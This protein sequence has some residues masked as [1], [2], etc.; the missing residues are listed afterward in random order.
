MKNL[1]IFSSKSFLLIILVCVTAIIFPS[2]A[3]A[4]S[5]GNS[6]PIFSDQPFS[7]PVRTSDFFD[8]FQAEGEENQEENIILTISVVIGLL[9]IASLVGIITS[10]LRLPYTVGLVLI[11]LALSLRGQE[12]I[13]IPPEIFLGLLVPPLIFEAAFHIRIKDLVKD[14]VPILALAIPGVLITTLL[15]GGVVA[16]GTGFPIATALV[17]GALVAATDPVAV[18]SLFRTLGVPKRL[19]VLLEGESLFNDGTAIVVFN[20]MIVIAVTG[21]FDPLESLLDFII[22]AGG[23]LAIGF[24]LG[25][26][27]SQTI[28]FIDESMISIT[29]TT[30]LAFGSYL[31]AEQFHVSGVLAVVAAGLVSGNIGPR[32]MSPSTR[33]L[34]F[35][36][37]GYA[38]FVANSVV[39]LLIGLQIDLP[40]LIADWKVIL[41]AITA[42]LV[43]RAVG[44]YGLSWVGK[45]I[46]TSFKN[47]LYWGGLRG[48]ISLALALSLPETLGPEREE[49]QV[50]AFGVVLFTLLVQGLTMKP[51]I[52]KMNLI[53]KN[54]AQEE[55]E[56][57]HA[58]S[59]MAKSAYE[60]LEQMYKQGLISA[61]IWEMMS[62][63]LQQ[64]AKA[65]AD[66]VTEALH[67][68]PSVEEEVFDTAMREMLAS[69]RNSLNMLLRDGIISEE[70]YAQLVVEV[71]TAIADPQSSQVR[72]IL[73]RQEIPIHGLMSVVVQ[74]S[75]VESVMAVLNRL[76][77]SVTRL[78]SFGGFLGRKNVTLLV[79]VPEGKEPAILDA[80][81]QASQDRIEFLPESLDGT[82]INTSVTVGG[83][84]T[85]TFDVERYEE[86]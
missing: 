41:W 12:N 60:R 72:I 85:F 71:D 7:K 19:Q 52:N 64:H 20:L 51:L 65:L 16:W 18:V 10:R 8:L 81:Q 53:K 26:L 46:S 50:M 3:V 48:A 22:V 49:I 78:S 45:D 54:E 29:L 56:R 40:V 57:R 39:F 68:D 70:T 23:G 58:R 17:F 77:I 75:D 38:A 76:G 27:I 30:V 14:L 63:P 21:F 59:V 9:L 55:Y 36:F 62:A 15:V 35:N 34:V 13:N 6:D 73:K 83:A 79:G 1:A 31:V 84:T 24:L 11:G 25:V 42:V 32:G 44:V 80:I 2:E 37:W 69:Q 33:I 28:R 66:A 5:E 61:Y 43:A 4:F 67:A 47:V 74:E 82:E 86:L